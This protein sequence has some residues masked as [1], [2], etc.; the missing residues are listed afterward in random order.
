MRVFKKSD[1]PRTLLAA[2]LVASF[3]LAAPVQSAV[4]VYAWDAGA[5]VRIA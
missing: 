3:T 5:D 2:S 4:V 1:T